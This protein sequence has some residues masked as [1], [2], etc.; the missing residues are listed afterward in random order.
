ML[1]REPGPPLQ[2]IRGRAWRSVD[3][4]DQKGERSNDVQFTFSS[5]QLGRREAE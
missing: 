3:G 4:G 2:G 5:E 1:E